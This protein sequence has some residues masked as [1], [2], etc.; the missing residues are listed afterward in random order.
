MAVEDYRAH[1][2]DIVLGETDAYGV[3]WTW[4]GPTPWGAS[5]APRAITAD[6]FAGDGSWDGT[7]Y[8][9]PRRL[10]WTG[11][12][13]A[14]SHAVLRQAEARLKA[15][16]VPR[17]ATIRVRE[18][19]FDRMATGRPDSEILWT[20]VD[21]DRIA[22]FSLSLL[23]PDPLLYSTAEH[24]NSTGLP[25]SVGGLQTPFQT[26]FQIPST[27]VT[28]QISVANAGTKDTWPR[29][30]IRGPVTNPRV[31]VGDRVWWLQAPVLAG[32]VIT[33]DSRTG[34]VLLGSASRTGWLRGELGPLQPGS[35][36]VLL[37][38]DSA[39]DERARLD[40]RWRDAWI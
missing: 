40:V 25:T 8:Y 4:H 32:E 34:Q 19:G 31:T 37:N 24:A 23:F 18:T 30:E 27:L 39:Y 5:P 11:M 33:L 21:G 12:A 6:R 10:E 35:T 38:G 14:P 28:G 3:E 9:G 29:W 16:L 22:S 2:G 7:A 17:L 36:T 1:I 20:D 26:P 13:I 15:T